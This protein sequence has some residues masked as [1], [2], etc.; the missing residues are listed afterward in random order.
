MYTDRYNASRKALKSVS[1]LTEN[2]QNIEGVGDA[3]SE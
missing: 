2:E 3:N 1:E